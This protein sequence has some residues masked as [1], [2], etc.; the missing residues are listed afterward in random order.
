MKLLRMLMPSPLLSATLFISWLMLNTSISVGHLLLALLMAVSIPLAANR[1]RPEKARPGRPGL[2]LRLL[3]R[4]LVDIV[5]ANIEVAR[6][7][8]GPESK[9]RPGWL[10]V[11]LELHDPHAISMLA[12]MVTLTPGT[13]SSCL[14]DDRRHLLVHALHVDDAAALVDSIKTRYE[15]P[16]KAIF[17]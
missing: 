8:V 15:L 7:V 5:T 9:L 12:A 16:L 1:W 13:V 6:Q 17:E 4:V 3:L 2:A 14:S 10:W 11:P